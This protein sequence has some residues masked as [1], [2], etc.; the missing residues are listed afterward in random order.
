[1]ADNCRRIVFTGAPGTGKT[2]LINRLSSLTYQTFP[3]V[4]RQLIAEGMS[5]PVHHPE[6]D[7]RAFMR[8]VLDLRI[9]YYQQARNGV[10]NFYDRGLPDGLAF[11]RI[12]KKEPSE[13]LLQTLNRFPY[14]SQVFFFPPWEEI[15]NQDPE[16]SESFEEANKLSELLREVYTELGYELITMPLTNPD[17]R[18]KFVLERVGDPGRQVS[19]AG[20]QNDI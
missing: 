14:D 18:L 10:L 8:R 3:E 12:M 2:T 13:R 16:R 9:L 20:L 17:A 11:M 4:S 19:A 5:A 1:M 7:G 6:S 15:F